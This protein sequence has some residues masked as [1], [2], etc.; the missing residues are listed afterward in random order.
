MNPCTVFA[1]FLAVVGLAACSNENEEGAANA[2]T[3]AEA[4][5]T[6]TVGA[7]ADPQL[8]VMRYPVAEL[9]YP[10]YELTG[11]VTNIGNE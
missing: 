8:Y 10:S 6:S 7:T 9:E 4:D 5:E 1:V 2:P 11:M 3:T